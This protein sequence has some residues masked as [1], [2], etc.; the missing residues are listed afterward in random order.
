[1]RQRSIFLRWPGA[2]AFSD[3]LLHSSDVWNLLRGNGWE[4]PVAGDRASRWDT[5]MGFLWQTM[6]RFISIWFCR[7]TGILFGKLWG[8]GC[9]SSR[10]IYC[11]GWVV[12][13]N[14]GLDFFVVL[15]G[16]LGFVFFFW[17]WLWTKKYLGCSLESTKTG[18]FFFQNPRDISTPKKQRWNF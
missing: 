14:E 8:I 5:T 7:C 4:G 9:P 18:L 16:W 6:K 15:I 1:M 3:Y 13:W 11:M 10:D 17:W 2:A 12:D